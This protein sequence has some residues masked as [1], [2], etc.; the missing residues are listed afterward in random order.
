MWKFCNFFACLLATGVRL[1]L[2]EIASDLFLLAWC[3]ACNWC[4]QARRTS[5]LILLVSFRPRNRDSFLLDFGLCGQNCEFFFFQCLELYRFF[6]VFRLWSFSDLKKKPFV[7]KFF[8]FPE[9]RKKWCIHVLLPFVF[10]QCSF[11]L[12]MKKN[13]ESLF[14]ILSF[15]QTLGQLLFVLWQQQ[16]QQPA[17]ENN[18]SIIDWLQAQAPSSS[19]SD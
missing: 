2:E 18:L 1:K 5:D 13:L 14:W 3:P 17:T 9:K 6:P 15:W 16:Q 11:I 7:E 4:L 19:I 8:F 10:G 12:E